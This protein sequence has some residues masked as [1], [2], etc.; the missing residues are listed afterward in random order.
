MSE[1]DPVT[2]GQCQA[3][4]SGCRELRTLEN[5][6]LILNL[7]AEIT[8]QLDEFRSRV[9]A[10][11][12]QVLRDLGY[13]ETGSGTRADTAVPAGPDDHPARRTED[14]TLRRRALEWTR[15][16]MT[17]I[18]LVILAAM[19][20]DTLQPYVSRILDAGVKLLEAWAK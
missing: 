12:D 16:N 1:N 2:Q 7:R 17:T 11:F 20:G 10:R 13:Q 19:A 4:R 5:Q 3:Q 18:L 6:N 14:V 8:G 9:N 15:D